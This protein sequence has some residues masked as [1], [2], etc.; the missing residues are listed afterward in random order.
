MSVRTRSREYVGLH[1][2]WYEGYRKDHAEFHS[3]RL[4]L[5]LFQSLFFYLH[6]QRGKHGRSKTCD[7][8]RVLFIYKGYNVTKALRRKTGTKFFLIPLLL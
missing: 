1:Q 3:F 8:G 4:L 2:T 7:F 6:K 5:P